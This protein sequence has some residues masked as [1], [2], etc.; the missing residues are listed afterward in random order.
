[1]LFPLDSALEVRGF[2]FAASMP[3]ANRAPDCRATRPLIACTHAA[4]PADQSQSSTSRR[5]CTGSD[6]A[7][8]CIATAERLGRRCCAGHFGHFS[9]PGLAANVLFVVRQIQAVGITGRGEH[10]KRADQAEKRAE[11]AEVAGSCRDC[12]LV[13]IAM[14]HLLS[15]VIS[16][17]EPYPHLLAESEQRCTQESD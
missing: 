7:D 14:R 1:M 13:T 3:N 5:A 15:I 10:R 8:A 17:A 16:L 6:C 4:A 12:V 2:F 11:T 9:T